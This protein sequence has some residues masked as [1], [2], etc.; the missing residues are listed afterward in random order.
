[1]PEHPT[2]TRGRQRRSGRRVAV[3]VV[4]I[5]TPASLPAQVVRG[6]VRIAGTGEAPP[7]ASVVL[8]SPA[9][10]FVAGTLAAP[11]GRYSLRAPS[12][13][14]FR[15][16]ARQ[17]G[18]APDSSPVL[19][20]AAPAVATFDATLVPRPSVLA[21]VNVLE[22]RRCARVHEA[23]PATA[24]L[25][26]EAQ[27]A[28]AAALTTASD[29]RFS[30]VLRRF[31]RVLDPVTLVPRRS[32]SWETRVV[33]SSSYASIPAESLA[34]HGFVRAEGDDQVYYAPDARTLTSRTFA[35]TH[36]LRVV[37]DRR[38]PA[39]LG[40]GFEPLRDAGR[41]RDVSGVLWLDRRTA[42][43]RH[44]AYRYTDARLDA[45]AVAPTT[46]TGRVEFRRLPGGGWI[47]S[48]WIVRV[49][50]VPPGG[51]PT[52]GASDALRSDPFLRQSALGSRGTL[53]EVGGT[54]ESIS[55]AASP[56]TAAAAAVRRGVVRGRVADSARA[57]GEAGVTVSLAPAA[58]SARAVRA[59]TDST[60]A[61]AFD[62]VAPGDY[63]LR[64]AAARFDT[65][66]VLAP[67]IP[68]T[69][70]PGADL[71][72]HV[73]SPGPTEALAALCPAGIPEGAMAL[74]GTVR[75]SATGARVARARVVVAWVGE[76]GLDARDVASRERERIAFTDHA[77]RYV[78][79]ALPAARPL[80]LSASRGAVRSP[81]AALAPSAERI[82][83][84]DLVVSA[85]R[86]ARRE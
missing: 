46:A 70:P 82:R 43:L 14:D 17:I 86:A 29:A 11:D 13:G 24:Q 79:C 56:A 68:L 26:Q 72:V 25:W 6:T 5:A 27:S 84:R 63:V 1:M 85:A 12:D 41:E 78:L 44:L 28:L 38:Q 80:E 7:A 66:N 36:C 16:R 15:V 21:S 81:R 18:F 57:Q 3:L 53:W 71:S 22:E 31:E 47:V 59:L 10:D 23:G 69:L 49:S 20:L 64:A 83:M 8:V 45:E 35:E 50:S 2:P 30:F 73:V 51:D 19:H 37:R 61:F 4:A 48:D 62:G 60:G 75:D 39:L 40:L 54:V 58:D 42:E 77:G 9:G 34:A 32:R 65:L 33:G 67:P 74:H 52:H 76:S 55:D